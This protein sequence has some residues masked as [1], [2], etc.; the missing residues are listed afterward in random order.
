MDGMSDAY[1][2][3]PLE[4]QGLLWDLLIRPGDQRDTRPRLLDPAVPESP[5]PPN[6]PYYKEFMRLPPKQR[7]A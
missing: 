5:P 3:P 6:D 7:M 2:P 4:E 1:G